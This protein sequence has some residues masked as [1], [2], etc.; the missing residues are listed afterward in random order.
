L[1][2]TRADTPKTPKRLSGGYAR[3][4][5]R[6]LELPKSFAILGAKMRERRKY[7]IDRGVSIF[8]RSRLV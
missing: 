7:A 5:P 4:P 6:S 3:L 2:L 8:D 1:A